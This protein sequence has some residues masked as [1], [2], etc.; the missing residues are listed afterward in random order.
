MAKGKNVEIYPYAGGNETIDK[1]KQPGEELWI[2][3]AKAGRKVVILT[4][5]SNED[6]AWDYYENKWI[7]NDN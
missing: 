3:N 5:G 7:L 6:D 4:T 1:F 2:V